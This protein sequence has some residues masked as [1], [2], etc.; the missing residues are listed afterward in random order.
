MVTTDNP[1]AN[2]RPLLLEFRLKKKESEEPLF[3]V[4]I[5]HIKLFRLL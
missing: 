1:T 2:L 3:G 4:Q 5:F